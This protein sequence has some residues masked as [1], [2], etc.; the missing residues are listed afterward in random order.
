MPG[1]ISRGGR[2]DRGPEQANTRAR[3][4]SVVNSAFLYTCPNASREQDAAG[5][6]VIGST[7]PLLRTV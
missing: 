4:F 3:L 1:E 7:K 6:A 2:S 5:I